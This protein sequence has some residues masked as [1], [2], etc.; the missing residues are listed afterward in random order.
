MDKVVMKA[1]IR[2]YFSRNIYKERS[3]LMGRLGEMIL[4][5]GSSKFKDP[6]A[7]THLACLRNNKKARLIGTEGMKWRE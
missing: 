4:L 5:R 7:R 1:W 6:G 2:C 3:Y